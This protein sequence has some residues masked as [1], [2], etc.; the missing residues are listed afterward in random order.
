[1]RA[2]TRRQSWRRTNVELHRSLSSDGR[3]WLKEV[4]KAAEEL[5]DQLSLLS[6]RSATLSTSLVE[7][8]VDAQ[9]SE[10]EALRQTLSGAI[11]LGYAARS[12]LAAPTGQP[13]LDPAHVPAATQSVS[14]FAA[15]EFASVMTLPDSVWAAY[16]AK[17]TR[18]LQK[19][20]ASM[21]VGWRELTR[22]RIEELLRC[23]YVLGCLD[24]ALDGQAP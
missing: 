10:G 3:K 6:P 15:T 23:G 19:A 1:M 24:E 18:K 14:D 7:R 22:E 9:N 4:W 12:V 20:G 5:S 13:P 11:R 16:A 17:A 21:S 8:Y 2:R